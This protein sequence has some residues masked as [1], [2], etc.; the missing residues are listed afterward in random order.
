MKFFFFINL[1]INFG[2]TQGK[3]KLFFFSFFIK[4]IFEL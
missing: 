3:G 4:Y 1:L 2:V